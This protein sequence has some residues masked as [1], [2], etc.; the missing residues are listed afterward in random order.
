MESLAHEMHLDFEAVPIAQFIPL[1][2][3]EEERS[4]PADKFGGF[5]IFIL[6][7]YCI[8][9]SKLERGF[10]TDMEDVGFLINR[11]LVT[12]DSLEPMLAKVLKRAM[13]F[14]IDTREVKTIGKTCVTF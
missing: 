3:G 13:E 12:M 8:V 9:L 7:P 11:N 4:L 1:P 14:D 5:D 2:E 10:D 6:D